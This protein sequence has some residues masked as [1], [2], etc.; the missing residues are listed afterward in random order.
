MKLLE[1]T[2]IVRH[3]IKLQDSKQPP[4]GPIYSL[5][6][7]ELEI[8]KTYIKIH[9]KTGFIRSFKSSVGALILFDKKSD[10]SLCLCVNYQ[11]LNNLTIKNEYLL[12][13]IREALDRLGKAMQFTQLDLTNAYCWV[14]IKKNDEWKTAFRTWYG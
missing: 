5:E 6:P 13:L 1:N 14:R 12:S 2:G 7:V 3:A 8:L 9:L 10:D 11:G 4:Y